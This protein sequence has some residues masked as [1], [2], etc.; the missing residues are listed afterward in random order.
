MAKNKSLKRKAGTQGMNDNS[1]LARSDSPC[2]I[3]SSQFC[4]Q[5]VRT[6]LHSQSRVRVQVDVHPVRRAV[7]TS[8]VLKRDI[9]RVIFVAMFFMTTVSATSIL[10]LSTWYTR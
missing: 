6:I 5:Q 1:K 2:A 7:W 3:P 10:P 9:F 8:T 4:Q